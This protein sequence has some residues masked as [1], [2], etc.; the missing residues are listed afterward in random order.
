MRIAP[1]RLSSL[2]SRMSKLWAVAAYFNPCRY[3]SRLENYRRFRE[4]LQAPLLTVELAF[5]G[6]FEL[7]PASADILI[8]RCGG[9]VM[10]QKERLLNIALEH[11]PD[12][13]EAVA[14]LDC[15]VLFS[16]PDWPEAA[17][18][19]LERWPLIQPFSGARDLL[20]P[21][22]GALGEAGPSYAASYSRGAAV[23][24]TFEY[25]V[26]RVP[27]RRL[28]AP[29]FAWAAR[30]ELI[31]RSGFYDACILG[32]GDRALIQAATGRIGP[33]IEARMPSQAH[34]AHYR[35]WAEPLRRS[36]GGCI[37]CIAGGIVHL[38]HGDF[39]DR[40][41]RVRF[42]DFGRFEFDPHRDI[43]L[44]TQACWRWASAKP[45][46]HAFA[47]DLFARRRED[48]RGATSLVGGSSVSCSP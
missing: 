24:M 43:S 2:Q 19:A 16:R 13:C 7:E 12:E 26:D 5:D 39:R 48:G 47:R 27:R 6:P 8:Q 42:D 21:G 40:Q 37:G 18:E 36:V 25:G 1:A 9:S 30:R 15:D 33:E 23:E 20:D 14:W 17:I 41:Y 46:L 34:A 4:Q 35:E 28:S 10:W 44:D 11:L 32:A 29:G 45:E 31:A 38:W 22:S 3:K